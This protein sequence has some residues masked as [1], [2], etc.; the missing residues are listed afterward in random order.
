LQNS[1]AAYVLT[2][3]MHVLRNVKGTMLTIAKDVHR[4][5]V[6]ALKNVE[7]WFSN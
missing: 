2:Y 3:A 4:Y 1:Y 6:A 5:A 7:G